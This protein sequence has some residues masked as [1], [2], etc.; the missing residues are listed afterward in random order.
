[1]NESQIELLRGGEIRMCPHNGA[2][3]QNRLHEGFGIFIRNGHSQSSNFT[4]LGGAEPILPRYSHPVRRV[5]CTLSRLDNI[6]ILGHKQDFPLHRSS[7]LGWQWWPRVNTHRRPLLLRFLA[8]SHSA[9]TP[10]H[11]F[12]PFPFFFGFGRTFLCTGITFS[13]SSSSQPVSDFL[14]A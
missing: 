12:F 6:L 10:S 13:P 3:T 8:D 7:G 11:H 5:H 4:F 14:L 2:H 9:F 1:M